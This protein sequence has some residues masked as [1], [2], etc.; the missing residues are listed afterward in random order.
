[1]L[2]C[3]IV[4]ILNLVSKRFSKFLMSDLSIK[5]HFLNQEFYLNH[6]AEKITKV[7]LAYAQTVVSSQNSYA[8]EFTSFLAMNM[9]YPLITVIPTLIIKFQFLFQKKYMRIVKQSVYQL[10]YRLSFRMKQSHIFFKRHIDFLR[11]TNK[12]EPI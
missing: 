2:K 7:K 8:F 4:T 10:Y 3:E 11:M 6:M 5:M 12:E 1:M 9:F